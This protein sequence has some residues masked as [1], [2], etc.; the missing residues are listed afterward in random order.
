VKKKILIYG[1]GAIGRGFLPWIFDSNYYDFYFVETNQDLI[2]QFNKNISYTTYK[3]DK[4][5]YLKKKI[6]PKKIFKINEEIDCINNFDL[7]ITCVGTRQVKKLVRNISFFKKTV[8]CLENDPQVV[9]YLKKETYKNNIF[10]GIPDVIS[11]NSASKKI[12]TDNKLNLITEKGTCYFDERVKLEN[13]D[14]EFI[15]AKEMRIQWLAKLYIHNSTHCIAAY[16][17]NLIKKKY[18]HEVMQNILIKKIVKMSIEELSLMLIKKFKLN[19]N[20][21]KSYA[22]KE[23]KRFSNKLLFDPVV[24][25]S[26]E[27]FRKLQPN[28]RLIGAANLCLSVGVIPKAISIGIMSAIN[29]SNSKDEDKNI[30]LLRKS[31]IPKFFLKIILGFNNNEPLY[32]YLIDKWNFNASIIKKI[33]N[34]ESR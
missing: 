31:L 17:G 24:R 33:L 13:T 12:L 14:I 21:V 16:L 28:E 30:K 2:L 11:S 3:I 23:L 32:E 10:F 29:Y 27:P 1:A 8:V 20:F 7:I 4:K 22:L 15:N 18:I 6:F 19:K 9:E 5:N 25:V 26:R 34:N